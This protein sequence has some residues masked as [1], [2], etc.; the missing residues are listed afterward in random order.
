MTSLHTALGDGGTEDGGEYGDDKLDN[1][2]D[3]FFFH[4]KFRLKVKG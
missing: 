3:S 1:G 2:L 4:G